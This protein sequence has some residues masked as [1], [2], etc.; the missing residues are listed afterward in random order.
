MEQRQLASVQKI[1]KI[2]P[3]DGADAIEKATVLGWECVIAKKDDFKVGDLV[4]YFEVDS[5]LPPMPEFEFLRDRKFRIRTIKLR[6]Q[7]SQGLVSPLTILPKRKAGYV[8]GDDVTEILGVTK[9]L[10]PTELTEKRMEDERVSREKS[11]IKRFLLR[12]KWYRRLF[13]V[14][15]DKGFPKF[16]HKTDEDRIQLFP[17]IC[18]KEKETVFTVAEKL[19]GQSGTWFLV[20]EK[21]GLKWLLF[22]KPTLRFGVCSRNV[23]LKT[24]NNSS[25]WKIA[26]KY[27][28]ESV[29][30]KLIGERDFVAIQGEIVGE[31]IQGNKY[32]VKDVDMY[33][34][35]LINPN[36]KENYIVMSVI[37]EAM[38]MKCVPRLDNNF[39]MLPTIPDMV[40]YAN[41][42]SKIYDTARE[43]IVVRNYESGLSFKVI[44]PKFLLKHEDA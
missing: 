28:I 38:G 33:V 40:D 44:S 43:G 6:G 36:G 41:G 20:K 30:N 10:S 12:N 23:Y 24:P 3:I 14:Q 13:M 5:V 31:G 8:E 22:R 19:D 4:V 26:K 16:I 35:N 15:S 37:M 7:V 2:E 21:S 39:K 42:V 17:N 29:L 25:Y 34:F 9:Y 27:N 11:R 18:E 32:K 1:L